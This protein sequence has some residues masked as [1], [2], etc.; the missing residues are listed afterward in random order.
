M[1]AYAAGM[2]CRF[3]KWRLISGLF[4]FFALRLMFVAFVA[5][6][7]RCVCWLKLVVTCLALGDLKAGMLLMRKRHQSQFGFKRDNR[8]I[9]RNGQFRCHRTAQKQ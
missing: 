7:Y 5:W 8:L 9:F 1:A 4:G 6:L 2:K 3:R